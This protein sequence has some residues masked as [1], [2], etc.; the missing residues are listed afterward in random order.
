MIVN[1][2]EITS[3]EK[4]YRLKFMNSLSG[5]KGVHLIGTSSNEGIKNIIATNILGE[6]VI[7]GNKINTSILEKGIYILFIEFL[8]GKRYCKK[9]I[10]E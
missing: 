5:Y 6:H 10:L 1:K 8:D 7:F 2:E 3:W 9:L 4:I